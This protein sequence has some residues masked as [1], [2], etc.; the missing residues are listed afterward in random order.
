MVRMPWATYLWPGLPQLWCRGLW[1]GLALAVGFGVLLNLLVMASFVWVELLGSGTLKFAWLATSVLWLG[2]AVASVW[3]SW[4][5][6]PRVTGSA[7]AMFR[8][9]L[10]EY[11]K[12]NWFEAERTLGR[13]LEVRP[14]DVEARLLLATLLRHNVRLTEALEQL[15]R[16][17]LLEDAR[18]WAREIE[19]EREAIAELAAEISENEHNQPVSERIPD[20]AAASTRAA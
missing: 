15:A 1:W 19:V 3:H 11:L 13:L 9:A 12:G 16:L 20:T 17:E 10:S 8:V 2:S 7:E 6:V 4:G 5:V 14:G 18:R